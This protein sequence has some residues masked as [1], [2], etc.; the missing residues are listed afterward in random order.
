MPAAWRLG[1]IWQRNTKKFIIV[2]AF[3]GQ[4]FL[5]LRFAKNVPALR[6]GAV[7]KK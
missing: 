5:P 4:V 6:K 2:A 1:R 7:T 3:H